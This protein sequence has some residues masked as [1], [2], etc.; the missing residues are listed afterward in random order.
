[1]GSEM[2][3]RDSLTAGQMTLEECAVVVTS[4][5]QALEVTAGKETKIVEAGQT[6]RVSLDTGCGKHPSQ[7][8]VAA[9]HSRFFLIPVIIGGITLPAIQEAF[10]SPDRP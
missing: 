8:P 4:R 7:R 3:I 10:E 9:A 5:A 1:M 6:Y 2:C